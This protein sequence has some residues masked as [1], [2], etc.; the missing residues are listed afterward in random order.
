MH[1]RTYSA[2]EL[3]LAG[4]RTYLFAG[5]CPPAP[6]LAVVGS[7]AARVDRLAL[8]PAVAAAAAARGLSIVSG[9]A[10]G[11]D[12]AAHR[13]ALA[14]AVP[15][16]A[17]LP[18]PPGRPYPPHHAPLFAAIAAAP[19]SGL[20]YGVDPE[21]PPCRAVF[22]SRNAVV[23]GLAAAVL[24]VEA[25]GRSGSVGTGRL[26]LAR[27]VPTAAVLGAAGCAELVGRGAR[28]LPA[29]PSAFAA[30]LAAW[31]AGLGGGAGPP[32]PRA[33]PA[34][35]AWLD[36]A[37][38]RAGPDGLG[39]DDLDRPLA[40]L[41]DLLAAEREGLIVESLPGRYRRVG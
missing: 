41:A 33:W 22:A 18:C 26:A 39:V 27:G 21:A 28:A 14:A 2:A 36:E 25:H 7:R 12:A 3:G 20:L 6:R 8:V 30:A 5:T 13:A 24:V 9:G 15:Q 16:L 23:V 37:L 40:R 17:V 19:G 4:R 1:V 38:A 32:S 34:R 10:I 35:L 29:E 11:V 31:L